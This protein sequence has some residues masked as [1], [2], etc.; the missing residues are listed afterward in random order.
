MQSD[1]TD[2]AIA[3][4][5]KYIAIIIDRFL[6]Y[7]YCT[8]A[9]FGT[10]FYFWTIGMVYMYYKNIYFE[11]IFK[12]TL[13]YAPCKDALRAA[14]GWNAIRNTG[15]IEL[16]AKDY[17]ESMDGIKWI[18]VFPDFVGT[19]FVILLFCDIFMKNRS[20]IQVLYV[21]TNEPFG[22]F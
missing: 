18:L 17:L 11:G 12:I 8:A 15:I 6:M 1:D 19:I 22:P 9:I 21:N 14:N 10:I 5:W 13:E 20:V 16:L 2:L 4:E 7:I 3:D